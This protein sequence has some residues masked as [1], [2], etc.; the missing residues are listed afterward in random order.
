M[1]GLNGGGRLLSSTAGRI[2]T[3]WREP[4]FTANKVRRQRYRE[5]Q[6]DQLD[7]LGLVVNILA[8]WNTI[9]T[10]AVLEQLRI[11]GYALKPE[12][13]AR[14]SPLTFDHI[15][16]LGRYAFA[17]PDSVAHGRLRPLRS[18]DAPEDE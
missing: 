18:P 9:Y 2:S 14:L 16:F 4:F 6:E 17:L 8:L 13:V 3:A 5:R 1:M 10:D 11:E 12:D 7:A 15:N